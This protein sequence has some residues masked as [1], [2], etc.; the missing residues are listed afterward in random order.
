MTMT[1]SEVTAQRRPTDRGRG[2]RRAPVPV[3]TGHDVPRT[4]SVL[5]FLRDRGIF[6]LWGLLL[7][8]FA[9]WASRTS[10]AST[11]PC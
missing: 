11:T 3:P 9:F 8:A 4:V 6:V 2:D 5:I 7:V 10:P 1:S